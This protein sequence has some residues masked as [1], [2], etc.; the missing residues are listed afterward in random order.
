MPIKLSVLAAVLALCSPA[1]SQQP[2]PTLQGS[3]I[4][5]AGPASYRGKWNARISSHR[6][7]LAAGSWI[8]LNERNDIVLQG[9]WSGQ[10]SA[11]GWKGTWRARVL[12]GRAYSG[13]WTASEPG[14]GSKT[15]ADM[16]R[17]AT[18]AGASGDWSTGGYGGAWRLGPTP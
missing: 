10:K 4:A 3:F 16:L 13:T 8:L 7:N 18:K 17:A 14:L 6:P 12:R 1:L 15:F 9:T 2:S 11:A 5:S